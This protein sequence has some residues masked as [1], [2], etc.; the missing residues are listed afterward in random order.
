MTGLP[1]NRPV[2]A[3]DTDFEHIAPL[4]AGVLP[5]D[6]SIVVRAR[7]G[8]APMVELRPR[9][10][11]SGRVNLEPFVP[12]SHLAKVVV[13]DKLIDAASGTLGVRLQLPNPGNKI[14]AGIR[15]SVVFGK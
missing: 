2:N 8:A 1:P 13:V 10:G 11:M 5:D 3:N 9:A 7:M 14:P 4:P 12:G 15:C 6:F